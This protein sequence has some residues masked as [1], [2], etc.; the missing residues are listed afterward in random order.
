[1]CDLKII[2]FLGPFVMF[3]E[4]WNCYC[5]K[6]IIDTILISHLHLLLRTVIQSGSVSSQP[7]CL[8]PPNIVVDLPRQRKK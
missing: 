8:A 2:V 7:L 1:M 3:P 5:A 6:E 4:T